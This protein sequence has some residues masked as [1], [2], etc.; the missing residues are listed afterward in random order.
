MSARSQLAT[1]ESLAIHSERPG[2]CVAYG[3]PLIV[4][5]WTRTATA[6]HVDLVAD[7]QRQLLREFPKFV[8]LTVIRAKLSM[9]VND[10][11]R[12]R[13]RANVDEFG[14]RTV[15]S[16]MVVEEGGLRA[17]FFRSVVTGVYFLSRNSKKQRV[18]TSIDDGLAWLFE[19]ID[20]GAEGLPHIGAGTAARLRGDVKRFVDDVAE[21]HPPVAD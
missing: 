5:V 7:A 18:C 13:S 8:I 3:G 15:R 12:E 20:A 14:E 2:F 9:S 11:V 21:R 16:V 6:E 4:P 1:Y 19:S 10:D 17:S